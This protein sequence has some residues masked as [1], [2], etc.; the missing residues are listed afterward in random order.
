MRRGRRGKKNKALIFFWKTMCVYNKATRKKKLEKTTRITEP[1]AGVAA[2]GLGGGSGSEC[3]L[4]SQRTEF[5]S[6]HP[7]QAAGNIL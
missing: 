2:T 3:A 5:S 7:H 4:L 6:W 1:S